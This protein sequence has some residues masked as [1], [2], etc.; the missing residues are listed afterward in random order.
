MLS[1]IHE[2]A[3]HAEQA[4][5]L[6][7]ELSNPHR[8]MICCALVD[9]ELSV[10]ELNERIALSQSALS[11]HLARLRQAGLVTTRKQ[12]LCVYYK[13]KDGAV[14]KIMNCLKGIY[15]PSQQ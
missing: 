4:A 9:G 11:Q 7:K 8:L 15:C 2:L 14:E 13:L 5:G 12:A 1:D 10:S 6:M 3:A